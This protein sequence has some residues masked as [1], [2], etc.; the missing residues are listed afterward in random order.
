MGKFAQSQFD[1]EPIR[2]L[3]ENIQGQ[4]NASLDIRIPQDLLLFHPRS[5]CGS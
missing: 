2:A 3:I 4:W 5:N 1:H